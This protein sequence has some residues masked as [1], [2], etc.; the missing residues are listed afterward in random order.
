MPTLAKGRP[1]HGFFFAALVCGCFKTRIFAAPQPAKK[2]DERLVARKESSPLL[3]SN[4]SRPGNEEL[5]EEE[6]LKRA[7]KESAVEYEAERVRHAGGGEGGGSPETD[8]GLVHIAPIGC[9]IDIDSGLV[10]TSVCVCS[11]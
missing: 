7:L 4:G 11:V 8:H 6:A 9:A 2:G 3:A 5:S 1:S 10:L